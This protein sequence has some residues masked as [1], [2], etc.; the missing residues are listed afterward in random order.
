MFDALAASNSRQYR[1]F[2]ILP[3]LRNNNRNRLAYGLFGSVAKNV[4]GAAVP[5][6]N[7]A[8]DIFAYDGVITGVNDR[9]Q[10][11]QPLFAVAK[12]NFNMLALGN[13]AVDLKHR[14]IAKQLHSAIYNDLTAVLANVLQL[15]GPEIGIQKLRTQFGERDRKCCLKQ[16][17]A[18][19]SHRLI[20]RK[21][22]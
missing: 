6:S 16:S 8:V 15:A 22:V 11:T 2:F 5:A 13:V 17:M 1:A 10:P 9:P 14:A 21:P 7:N 4:L 18:T 12:R 3:V 20:R 19:P